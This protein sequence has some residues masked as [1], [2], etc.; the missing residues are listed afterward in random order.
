[1]EIVLCITIWLNLS[2]ILFPDKI[3]LIRYWRAFAII[4]TLLLITYTFY[5][6]TNQ[7]TKEI[8]MLKSLGA[9]SFMLCKDFLKLLSKALILPIMIFG[10]CCILFSIYPITIVVSLSIYLAALILV[11]IFCFLQIRKVPLISIRFQIR[12]WS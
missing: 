10:I 12:K 9:S 4:Y 7:H 1:M 11:I 8:Q 3:F 2:M 5:N 6:W